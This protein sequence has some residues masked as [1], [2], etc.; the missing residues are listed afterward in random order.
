MLT[1]T[2]GGLHPA[3]SSSIPPLFARSTGIPLN[4]PPF[5]STFTP[6]SSGL[7]VLASAALAQLP[8]TQGDG[9]FPPISSTEPANP[10]LLNIPGF[11]LV[12]TKLIRRIW[13]LEYVD[14]WEL[15]PETWRRK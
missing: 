15:L 11:T 3:Y 14:M 1:I 4:V 2:K 6:S 9:G 10:S 13:G 7:E 8:S 12:P 5:M